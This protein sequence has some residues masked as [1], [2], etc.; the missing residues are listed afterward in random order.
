M[1][2][3]GSPY[4]GEFSRCSILSVDSSISLPF[5]LDSLGPAV[6]VPEKTRA[7]PSSDTAARLAPCSH[8]DEDSLSSTLQTSQQQQRDSS[9]TSSQNT[10]QL[11]DRFGSDLSLATKARCADRDSESPLHASRDMEQSAA[12]SFV[13]TKALWEI[14]K[15]LSQAENV[16][17]AGSSAASSTPAVP[18]LLSDDDIFLS[19]RKKSGRLQDS[20]FTSSSSTT[21]EPRT[22]S[23]LL[24][25]RSSSDSMLT[26]EKSRESS[27]GRESMTS[28]G[29]SGYPSPKAVITAPGAGTYV[30][31][32]NSSGGGAGSSLVLSKSARRAEPEGCSAAPPDNT[33]PLQPPVIKPS[34]VASTQQSSTPA[35]T[36]STPEEEKQATQGGPV[37][38]SSSSPI[39]EDTDQGVISD[40]SSESSL[41]VRVAKLLQS[42]SPATMVSSTPSL[43]DQ[44]ESK[45][46]GK[47]IH[48][49]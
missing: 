39:L 17:S 19:L 24:W 40:G 44:E 27:I 45:A 33:V 29:Q 26:S 1:F 15:L 35:D 11:G 22:R 43:T 13:S 16:V 30:M 28:S 2:S 37:E 48:M 25:A 12:D 10:I 14:R 49:L 18:R 9:L 34:P 41:A 4:K 6:S 8:S 47:R 23:P 36:T 46:R 3:V 20:L 42:E 5:S 21:G 7:S 31:P 32:Q 38:S